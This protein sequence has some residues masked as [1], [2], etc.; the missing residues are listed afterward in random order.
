LDLNFQ[1]LSGEPVIGHD[2]G[3]SNELGMQ[4]VGQN[5]SGN[6]VKRNFPCRLRDCLDLL[7]KSLPARLQHCD[8]ARIARLPRSGA[9]NCLANR[10]A[11]FAQRFS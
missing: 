2:S 10:T 11:P 9:Q 3:E 7:Q 1:C 5:T 4:L 6:A 8:G